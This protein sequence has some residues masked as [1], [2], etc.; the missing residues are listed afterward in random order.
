M[1]SMFF[2]VFKNRLKIAL[3][4]KV[5]LFWTLLFPI[6]LATFFHL[7][8]SNLSASESF[9]VVKVGVIENENYQ[10]LPGFSEMID[11]LG[12]EG[13]D[14]IL[15]VH[16]M[17]EKEALEQLQEKAIDGYLFVDS[18][19]HIMVNQNGMEA[20]I[21]K[22]IVDQYYQVSSVTENLMEF[23]PELI[24]DGI[25]NEFGSGTYLESQTISNL[26]PSVTYF[27]T[28]IGMVCIYGGFWG[29]TAVNGTEANLSK[30]GARIAVSPA[31]KMTVLLSSLAVAFVVL[32]IEMLLLLAF[33][34]FVLK[35]SFGGQTIYVLLLSFIGC[36]AGISVGLVIG[37]TS[38][39][40]ENSKVSILLAIAMTC[41]FLAGMMIGNLRYL[42]EQYVPIINDINPV[43]L[44]TDG[45]YALYYYPTHD[46]YFMN[47]GLL[48]LFI[49]VMTLIS[50]LATRRKKYDSI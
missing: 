22:S 37:S 36:L 1:I 4:S 12:K 8:F 49:V 27:Y 48:I 31:H 38:R 40:S 33:L 29:I 41:S 35:V 18:D 10:A 42:I 43:A 7:A 6:I 21:L 32:F 47:L 13:T 34:T 14:Q 17:N 15:E 11:L 46:R 44:I 50:Y 2:H 5:L 25:L 28:L 20:T 26:D 3:R 45:L 39:K 23:N 30:E 19:I 9:Q 16:M 24:R